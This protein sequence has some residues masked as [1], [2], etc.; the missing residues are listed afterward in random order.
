[1]GHLTNILVE[2]FVHLTE[3]SEYDIFEHIKRSFD[4]DLQNEKIDFACAVANTLNQSRGWRNNEKFRQSELGK[5]LS[6]ISKIHSF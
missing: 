3:G 5:F 1:M 4:L 2:E 6:F